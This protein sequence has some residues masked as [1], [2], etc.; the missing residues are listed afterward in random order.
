MVLLHISSA[1][2]LDKKLN[3]D[4]S[5]NHAKALSSCI[6]EL[7]INWQKK[8]NIAGLWHDWPTLAGHQLAKNCAPI[9]L[10]KGILVIGASHPQWRQALLYNRTQLLANLKAAG[11]NIK[12]IRIH[13][14]HPAPTNKKETE[15]NIWARHPS[16]TDIHGVSTC[17]ACNS[18]APA[19]EIS[20]WKMCS[21]CRRKKL[22][23]QNQISS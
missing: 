23:P 18:P 14:H 22:N 15:E 1:N 6:D 10:R 9:S 12:E 13:Q 5:S 3:A 2:L 7:K 4:S 8:G 20:R 16:R 11:H 19:G 17:L 21:F